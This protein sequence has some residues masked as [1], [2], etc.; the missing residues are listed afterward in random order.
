MTEAKKKEPIEY[1]Y[2]V[3]AH[4]PI[5]GKPMP[6]ATFNSEEA[7]TKDAIERNKKN[8][9]LA[10]HVKKIRKNGAS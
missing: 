7:A 5:H 6:L 1:A 2:V 8:S 10:H 9:H 3:M 4:H